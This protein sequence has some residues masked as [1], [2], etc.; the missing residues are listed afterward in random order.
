MHKGNIPYQKDID[1]WPHLR[2]VNLPKIDSEIE[3]LIGS[4]VPKALE[5]LEVWTFRRTEQ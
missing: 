1:L 2:S 5:P 4:D 3:L